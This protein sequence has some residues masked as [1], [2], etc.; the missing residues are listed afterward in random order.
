LDENWLILFELPNS[1]A[2]DDES[3]SVGLRTVPRKPVA[4]PL[5]PEV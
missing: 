3:Q 5:S 1:D 4:Q 2:S